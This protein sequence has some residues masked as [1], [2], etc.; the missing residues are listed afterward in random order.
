MFDGVKVPALNCSYHQ[1]SE[2]GNLMALN[3]PFAICYEFN[4]ENF[5]VSLRSTDSGMNVS[6]I[7]TKH[8]GGGHRN[9]AGLSC[10]VSEFLNMLIK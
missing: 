3:E 6:E 9:A 2:A 4:G 8:G 5:S 7:A 1:T 10:T